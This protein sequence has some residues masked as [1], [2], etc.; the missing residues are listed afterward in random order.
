MEFLVY[1]EVGAI[2]DAEAAAT[3][4]ERRP[5]VLANSRGLALFDVYGAFRVAERIGVSGSPRR[6]TNY[7]R[8]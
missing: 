7:T 6:S 1:M 3:L 2:G 5:S 8:L 4:I